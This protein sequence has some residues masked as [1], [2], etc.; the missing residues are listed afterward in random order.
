MDVKGS[1]YQT[2]NIRKEAKVVDAPTNVIGKLYKG[3]T[4]TGSTVQ[5][6]SE[7]WIKLTSVNGKAVTDVRYVAGW[8]V[9][10]DEVGVVT[11]P[12]DE[13][14]S[15]VKAVVHYSNGATQELF[16]K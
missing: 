16:P 6:G 2:T 15:V 8:V 13:A 7:T 4:F 10:Y 3:E 11:P 5:S 14:D 9:N 12:P 1:A